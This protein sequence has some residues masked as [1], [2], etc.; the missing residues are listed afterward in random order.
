MRPTLRVLRFI[1]A[2]ITVWPVLLALHVALWL[3]GLLEALMEFLVKWSAAF[4]E[5]TWPVN[6]WDQ[7]PTEPD[8][9]TERDDH[10]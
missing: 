9:K 7:I 1:L 8:P 3:L 10:A 2:F 6:Y 4:V 5:W